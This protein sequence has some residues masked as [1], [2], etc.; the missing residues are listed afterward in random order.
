M[1]K[2]I[3]LPTILALLLLMTGFAAGLFLVEKGPQYFSNASPEF[4]PSQIKITNL[5]DSGLTISWITDSATSGFVVYDKSTAL[6]QTALDDRDQ[7]SGQTGSFK[8]HYV[9]L[10]NLQP[11]TTYYY[12][13][14]SGSQTYNQTAKPLEIITASLIQGS[15]PPSDVATG[16]IFVSRQYAGRRSNCLFKSGRSNTA[17]SLSP[18]VRRLDDSLKQCLFHR[19]KKL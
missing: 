11:Q 8:N 15:L 9:T 7:L 3:R 19:F 18:I 4:L 2:F 16:T 14:V 1:K 10:K 5:S 12:R 17:I 6:N 13:L